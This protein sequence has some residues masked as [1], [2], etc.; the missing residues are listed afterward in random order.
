MDHPVADDESAP[1]EVAELLNE[2]VL[3]LVDVPDIVRIEEQGG[4]EATVY[5]IH[6]SPEDRGRVIG[7]GGITITA[8]R[9]LIERVGILQGKRRVFVEVADSKLNKYPKAQHAPVLKTA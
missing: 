9:N 2:I 7:K 4:G 3:A 1:L 5:L 6:V 8:I